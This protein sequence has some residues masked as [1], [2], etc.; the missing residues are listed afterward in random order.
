[1]SVDLEADQRGRII[2]SCAAIIT[3]SVLFVILRLLSRKL[4]RA[5]YWVRSR[6]L[7]YIAKWNFKVRC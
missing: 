5:G 2:G 6:M 7:R 1:M 3:L 4:S